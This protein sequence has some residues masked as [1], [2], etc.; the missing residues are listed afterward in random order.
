MK[1]Y[2]Y[3]LFGLAAMLFV[4]PKTAL[5]YLD[6]VSGSIIWQA[7]IG[8]I[9]ALSVTIRLYWRK[10]RSFFTKSEAKRDPDNP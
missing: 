6:P 4:F 2:E 8:G 7:L 3:L 10:I 9:L 1:R 5:A